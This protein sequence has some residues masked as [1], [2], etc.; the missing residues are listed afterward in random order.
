MLRTLG[1]TLRRGAITGL[2][3]EEQ[4]SDIIFKGYLG[5]LSGEKMGEEQEWTQETGLVVLRIAVCL[6][7][8]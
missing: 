8:K 5:R 3:K 1:L 2:S 4:A 6:G 7:P